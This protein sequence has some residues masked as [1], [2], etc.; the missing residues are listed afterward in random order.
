MTATSDAFLVWQ[1]YVENSSYQE[2]ARSGN[3]TTS[4]RVANTWYNW[5]DLNNRLLNNDYQQELFSGDLG[6]EYYNVTEYKLDYWGQFTS[7]YPNIGSIAQQ[8]LDEWVGVGQD[9]FATTIGESIEESANSVPLL[10]GQRDIRGTPVFRDLTGSTNEYLWVVYV[11]AEGECDSLVD[12]KFNGISY[13]D[14]TLSPYLTVSF[15]AGTDT[16]AALT[17]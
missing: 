11:L 7:A 8:L 10:Y 12:I 1:G 4:L 5:E 16:Q 15:Y 9:E 13:T 6:L 17:S 3:A 2:D 14:A